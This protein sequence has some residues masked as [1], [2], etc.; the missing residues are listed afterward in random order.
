MFNLY[1]TRIIAVVI[2]L[3]LIGL[4]AL[5]SASETALTSLS[6]IRIRQMKEEGIKRAEIV[7]KLVDNTN[8][9]LSAILVGNNVVNI[10]AS[11]LATS[12]AINQFGE[13]GVTISTV[14]MTIIVLIFAEITP[15]SLASNNPEKVSLGVAKYIEFITIVLNPIAVVFT[16]ITKVILKIFRVNADTSKPF[17][18]EEELKTMLDVSH[19]EGVLEVTE[20]KMIYNVFEFGDSQVKD[21]MIPRA[22]IVALD[23]NSSYDEIMQTFRIQQFSRI[24]IYEEEIDNVIGILHV[25]NLVLA[26]KE[27]FHIR[28]IIHESYFTYE[29][30]KTTEL[31][32][33]MRKQRISLTI[34]LDEYGGTVGLITMEDLVEEIVGDI[35]DEY[36]EHNIGIEVIK[37]DEYII[38]GSIKIDEVN[39]MI[40]TNIESEDFDT[41]GGFVIGELGRFPEQ[42]EMIEYMNLKFIIEEIDRNRIKKLKVLT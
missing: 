8:K 18:T 1:S 30:K 28:D 10:G 21:V 11:A 13:K 9:M 41:I 3:I 5:F 14:V 29:Y 7:D 24:P 2:L 36:D 16:Y 17:I 25:K 39:D 22:D 33:E 4:S 23:I 6:K 19:E 31:F 35:E 34:V 42:G 15:K 26:S 32:E 37:E 27:N 12:I 40:G 20:R 38:D